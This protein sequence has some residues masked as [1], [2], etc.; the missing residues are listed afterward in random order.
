MAED[1]VSLGRGLLNR[2]TYNDIT[3]DPIFFPNNT[4]IEALDDEVGSLVPPT[5]CLLEITIKIVWICLASTKPV[6]SN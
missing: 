1:S 2:E 5:T 3:P 4:R 6:S